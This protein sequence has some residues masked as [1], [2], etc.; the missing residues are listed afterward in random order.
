MSMGTQKGGELSITML[1]AQLTSSFL[2]LTPVKDWAGDLADMLANV[3][4]GLEELRR[5]MT[6]II[7][8]V[9]EKAEQG[10]EKLRDEL[11]VKCDQVQLLQNTDH[12]LCGEFSSSQQRI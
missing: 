7:D 6:K 11:A 8:R 10:H 1:Q 4:T 3:M 2:G 5:D 9:E 12:F